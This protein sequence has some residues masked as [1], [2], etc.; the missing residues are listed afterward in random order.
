MPENAQHVPD[1]FWSFTGVVFITFMSVNLKPA[2]SHRS[3]AAKGDH[4]EREKNV[5]IH[6]VSS[7]K[8]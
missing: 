2:V 1:L 8:I 3:G 7:Y 4:K 5:S 6:V